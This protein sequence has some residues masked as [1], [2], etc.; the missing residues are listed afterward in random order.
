MQLH[1]QAALLSWSNPRHTAECTYTAH[2]VQPTKVL[3]A[4]VPRTCFNSTVL[5]N[6][7]VPCNFPQLNELYCS[8]QLYCSPAPQAPLQLHCSQWAHAMCSADVC[9][10]GFAYANVAHLPLIH[11]RLHLCKRLR[12]GCV[13]VD[14][15]TAA[16]AAAAE[17]A[18]RQQ[19]SLYK[20]NEIA[21]STSKCI[22][23]IA[24]EHGCPL[25]I[26][27]SLHSA[28]SCTAPPPLVARAAA[29]AAHLCR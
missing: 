26:R 18:G 8:I 3:N 27:G 1:Q 13:G 5:L 29:A 10:A 24:A 12:H 2:L 6:P 25:H 22:A 16:A 9:R 20:W 19:W 21:C 7:A 14:P 23:C 11:Q 4:A 28:S 17:A 15:T